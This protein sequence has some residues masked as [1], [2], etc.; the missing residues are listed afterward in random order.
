MN[1]AIVVDTPIHKNVTLKMQS[2]GGTSVNSLTNTVGLALRIRN[3]RNEVLKLE[4]KLNESSS[5]TFF[6]FTSGKTTPVKLIWTDGREE[7]ANARGNLP[8]PADFDGTAIVPFSGLALAGKPNN[9]TDINGRP[10]GNV[11][12]NIF[13]TQTAGEFSI[14]E[15]NQIYATNN[16]GTGTTQY[17]L[18]PMKT[19]KNGAET[20]HAKNLSSWSGTGVTF[21]KIEGAVSA[22]LQETYDGEAVS[23]AQAITDLSKTELFYADKMIVTIP[24]E[25]GKVLKSL[26]VDGADVTNELKTTENG[27][28][29][30]YVN[31]SYENRAL[32]VEAEYLRGF[33]LIYELNGGFFTDESTVPRLYTSENVGENV[34]ELPVPKWANH[35]FAGWYNRVEF[36]H[37]D[38][39][40]FDVLDYETLGQVGYNNAALKL[41]ARWRDDYTVV[42]NDV[43]T[44]AAIE[45]LSV[46]M[47]DSVSEEIADEILSR[48]G[49]EYAV[50]ADEACTKAVEFPYVGKDIELTLYVKYVSKN[51]TVRFNTFSNEQLSSRTVTY[52]DEMGA[53]PTISKEGY[54]FS[55]WYVDD[56]YQ[57]EVT[58][59]TKIYSDR[60]FYA[61]WIKNAEE[62]KNSPLKIVTIV[63]GGV[64]AL[65][66]TGLIAVWIV[67]KKKSI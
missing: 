61:Q 34:I 5:E 30:E 14:A 55:G 31:R 60:V 13:F 32:V 19:A 41:Y 66:L 16:A 36:S 27:R 12:Q 1:G 3:Y 64:A 50:Y 18:K 23:A 20:N 9:A 39:I 63:T 33:Y 47:G 17:T 2:G 38:A 22:T 43:A 8:I 44:G 21:T 51:F 10:D 26:K 49:Q 58:P 4:W 29:Y 15:I 65:S 62:V 35:S 42:F 56:A 54:T 25:T 7:T 45:R 37:S 24:E 11:W 46:K 52:G 57:E 48:T 67:T 53:L 40:K 6:M 59:S 28:I